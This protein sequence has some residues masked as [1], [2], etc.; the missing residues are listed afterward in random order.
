METQIFDHAKIKI[1]KNPL[2][3]TKILQDI[4][5]LELISS[6]ITSQNII[7]QKPLNKNRPIT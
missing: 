3:E 1:S 5:T 4:T 7:I 6:F 2:K